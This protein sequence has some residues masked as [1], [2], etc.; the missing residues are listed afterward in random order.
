MQPGLP[1]VTIDTHI[2][3]AAELHRH[4]DRQSHAGAAD[5]GAAR[6]PGARRVPLRVAHRADQ[7]RRDPAVAGGGRARAQRARRDDQRDGAGGARDRRSASS[8]TTRSSTSRTSGG[9]CASTA[10]EGSTT[11][12]ARI[13]VDASLEVRSSIVYATMII[14]VAAGA[15]L[16]PAGPHRHVLPP[17]RPLVRAGGARVA[18]GRADRHAG[19]E[20]DPAAQGAARAPRCRLSCAWL[21]RGYGWAALAGHPSGRARPIVVVVVDRCRRRRGRAVPRGVAGSRRSRSGTS[22]GHWITK[23]GTSLEEEVRIVSRAGNGAAGRSRRRI[24]SAPTSARPSWRTRWPASTSART[25]SPS[26]RTPTTS[27]TLA[28][29]QEVVDSYPG[30][31]HDV[32]T[33]LNERIDEVL[34]GTSEPIVVRIFGNDLEVAPPEGGVVRDVTGEVDGRRAMPFV[35]FQEG[36]PAAPGRGEPRCGAALRPQARRRAP[37][38]RD[39]DGERGGRRHLPRRASVRRARLEHAGDAQQRDEPARASARHAGRRARASGRR[40]RHPDQAD[41]ERR[42]SRRRVAEHRRRC[43]RRRTRPRRRRRRRRGPPPGRSTS[44]SGTTRSCS[45]STRSGRTLRSACSS[46]ASAP[47]SRSSSSCRR[48]S[49]AGGWRRSPSSPCRWPSSVACWRR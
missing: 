28:S 20:H 44:R 42:P 11:S 36:R 25:G 14:V 23:P 26:I 37:G 35:E 40:R 31:F 9:V 10:Q 4:V 5:R 43:R 18:G 45:A 39:H 16:P 49:G 34:T 22:S 19:A 27:K 1:G 48:R 41:A 7:R 15:G 46:T 2:F 8:S 38:G 29:I 17:A 13:I 3:R 47:Q 32:Q 30:T 6:D 33:Y 12:P 21:K 24:T